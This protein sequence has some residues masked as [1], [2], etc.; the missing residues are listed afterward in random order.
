M[1]NDLKKEERILSHSD[2]GV[3]AH[4]PI[5]MNSSHYT[6]RAGHCVLVKGFYLNHLTELLENNLLNNV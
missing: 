5:H 6:K 2:L 1:H 4:D 3:R